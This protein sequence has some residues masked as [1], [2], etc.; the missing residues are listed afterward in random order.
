MKKVWAMI[1]IVFLALAG[2]THATGQAGITVTGADLVQEKT[3]L[4][5]D[6][7]PP[8]AFVAVDTA[9]RASSY[10]LARPPEGL[11][12]AAL[13]VSYYPVFVPLIAR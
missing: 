8:A 2:W 3:Y 13:D 9:E 5:A 6:I 1:L 4:V 10:I 7:T 11:L 12:T